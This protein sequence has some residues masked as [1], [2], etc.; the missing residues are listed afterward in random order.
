MAKI[1]AIVRP[2]SRYVQFNGRSDRAEFW[3]FIILVYIV[4]FGA[5]GALYMTSL[6]NGQFDLDKFLPHY[7]QASPFIA[8]FDLA[9]LLPFLAV[10]VR[11]LHDINRSGWWILM[12]AVVSMLA[13]FTFFAVKGDELIDF[14]LNL[15]PK[16][17]ALET[18]DPSAMMNPFSMMKSVLKL[19]WPMYQMMIPWVLFPSLAAQLVLYAF[20]ALPGTAGANRFGLPPAKA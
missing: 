11:R 5:Y 12:P 2:L 13:Y 1:P 15:A 16:M 7:L 6:T 10:I 19:E 4:F 3:P 20:L 9:I 17:E 14:M 18:G 8:L